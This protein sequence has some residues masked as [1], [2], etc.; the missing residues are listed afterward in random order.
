GGYCREL[1]ISDQVDFIMSTLSKATGSLGG[2]VACDPKYVPLLQWCANSYI[3]QACMSPAD[4]AAAYTSLHLLAS[5]SQVVR[6]L[7]DN[8]LYMREALACLGIDLGQSRSPVIP[9]YIDDPA[10]LMRVNRRLY[11]NG[12]F[13]VSVVYPAVK[14]SE[15]RI[16]LIVTARHTR[17][18]IDFTATQIARCLASE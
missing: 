15:G 14:P 7:H 5:P 17:E 11:E 3:F 4:A 8:N 18:Q 13:S 10:R 9:I 12:I 2:F 16:R 6:K 1:G